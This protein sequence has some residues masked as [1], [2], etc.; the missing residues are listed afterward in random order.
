MN[1]RLLKE[2]EEFEGLGNQV[3]DENMIVDDKEEDDNLRPVDAS[4]LSSTELADEVGASHIVI[5][6]LILVQ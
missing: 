4:T 5:H 1:N 3:F 2:F 6:F